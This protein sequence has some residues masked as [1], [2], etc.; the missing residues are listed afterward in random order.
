L[1][2]TCDETITAISQ[3]KLNQDWQNMT[4]LQGSEKQAEACS[5]LEKKN[6]LVIFRIDKNHDLKKNQNNQ[7]FFI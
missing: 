7:I 1:Q 2:K 4:L 3:I 5:K 6:Y